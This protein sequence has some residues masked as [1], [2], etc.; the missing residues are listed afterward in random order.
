M[1]ISQKD[2]NIESIGRTIFEKIEFN[3]EMMKSHALNPS[4]GITVGVT[5]AG[6]RP[7]R[8][9]ARTRKVYSFFN[10]RSMHL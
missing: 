8:L 10:F 9:E 5:V 4:S 7:K 2:K 6:P 3:D 1:K